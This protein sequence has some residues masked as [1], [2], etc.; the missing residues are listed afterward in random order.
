M[1]AIE[2]KVNIQCDKLIHLENSVVMYGVYN[3]ATLEKLINTVHQMHNRTTSNERLF[4]G[5]LSTAYTWYVNKNG[6]HHYAINLFLY[7]RTLRKKYIKMYNAAKYVCKSNKNSCKRLFANL[8]YITVQTT[9]NFESL[10]KQFNQS[11]QTMI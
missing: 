10:R 5:E 3:A 11:T 2:I 7:L 4:A 6:V 1:K 9:R 8:S